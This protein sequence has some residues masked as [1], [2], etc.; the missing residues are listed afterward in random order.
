MKLKKFK[1]SE[2]EE[3]EWNYNKH[4][5]QQLDHLKRSLIDFSQLKNIVIWNGLVIAGNGLVEAARQLGWD[6]IEAF[7]AT[8][9]LT[10][11]KARAFLISDNFSPKL[12]L[13]DEQSLKDLLS[14]FDDPLDIP[15]ITED[16]LN[17]INDD[18]DIIEN[19]DLEKSSPAHE[20]GGNCR[21]VRFGD[22]MGY[23][24]EEKTVSGIDAFCDKFSGMN[25]EQL[26]V[27]CEKIVSLVIE[28]ENIFL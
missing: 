27:L 1:L 4:P 3:P 20:Y 18:L 2:I 25:Q 26:N 13:P 8:G 7:D 28:N 24:T 17:N 16:F 9:L 15:G 12:A 6:E 22:I 11:K 10:E 23:M 14:E 21:C 19:N 5:Q